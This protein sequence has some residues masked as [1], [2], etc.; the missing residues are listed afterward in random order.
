MC[1]F[2]SPEELSNIKHKRGNDKDAPPLPRWRIT[3]IFVDGNHRARASPAHSF[4]KAH[5]NKLLRA[6][7]WSRRSDPE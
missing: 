6:G 5:F 7:W 2:G 3:C 1:Q 4:G